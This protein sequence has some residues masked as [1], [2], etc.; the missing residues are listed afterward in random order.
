MGVLVPLQ[1]QLFNIPISGGVDTKTD[2]FQVAA[3][4]ASL[5][6]NARFQK[7]GK[8]SKRF[9]LVSLTTSSND[10]GFAT[11][12]IKSIVSDND[13]LAT[14]TSNGVYAYSEGDNE[15]YKQT[16]FTLSS[17]IKS[18][19]I[20]KNQFN[21]R[22]PDF[23]V[24]SDGTHKLFTC[25]QNSQSSL[26]PIY[27]SSILVVLED[28]STG[29]RKSATIDLNTGSKL[30]GARC[31]VVKDSGSLYCHVYYF[32]GTTVKRNIYDENLSPITSGVI[33]IA[34]SS[35]GAQFDICKDS[36][37]IYLAHLLGTTLDL[38]NYSFIGVQLN[39]RTLTVTNALGTNSSLGRGLSLVKTASNIHI[40]WCGTADVILRGFN[41]NLTNAITEAVLATSE[42]EK[43]AMC[44][45]GNNLVIVNDSEAS[46]SQS[47]FTEYS[48]A[49]FTTTYSFSTVRNL[50]R[51]NLASQPFV[52]ESKNFVI[53]KTNEA[54]NKN[55]YLYNLTDGYIVQRFSPG[56]A[57]SQS[58][59]GIVVD[60]M[61][62]KTTV[63]DN[64]AMTN[65]CRL[66]TISGTDLIDQV[67]S[68]TYNTHDFNQSSSINGKFKVGKSLY[69]ISGN[70]M[71][72][73]KLTAFENGF[74]FTPKITAVTAVAGV[75]NPN[76]SSKNFVYIAV[77]EFYNAQGERIL[78]APSPAFTLATTGA[79]TQRID[80]SVRSLVLSLKSKLAFNNFDTTVGV[81]IYRTTSGGS[82]FYRVGSSLM[83]FNNGNTE[84]ISDTAA[85]TTI[86][87][88]E[89][90]YTTGDVL[91]NDPAPSAEFSVSGGN[92]LFLGGLE[93]RDEVAYSK[94]QLFGEAVAF[95]D[96]FR[97]R[98]STGTNAD[99]TPISAL[100][101]MDAKLIIFRE[102]SIYYIQG[103]GPN[104]LGVGSF[105][106][107]E[108]VQSDVGCVDARSVLSMPNGLMFKSRKGIYLLDRGLSVSYIGAQVE[109][110]NNENIISS[111][112]SDKFNECRFYTD[113]GNCLV[114]NYLFG[115]WSVFL[116]QTSVDADNWKGSPVS[117][118]GDTVF[119][120]SEGTYLDNGATGF[121]PMKY[122]SPWLKLDMIQGYFR[123]YRLHILGT[124]KSNH[125]L[126]C[127]IYTDYDETV[128][129]DYDLI[130]N[131]TDQPQYQFTIHIPKQ[132]CESIKFEIFDDAHESNSNG[133]AYDLSNIQ[134]EIGFKAGGFK[135]AR[136]K[137][138]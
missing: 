112:L 107:P 46:N 25:V 82:T 22:W 102:Q 83:T 75:A 30:R 28:S 51:I 47:C 138:Y 137:S 111:I 64:V 76:I 101:Y 11:A 71:E 61:V 90:L 70:V 118:I 126:K 99:K 5:L 2:P 110:Y 60:A 8:L 48:T 73:D 129:D 117:I 4:N 67:A 55:Y 58:I 40:A 39:D 17:V 9:G 100:G 132:K 92:R 65:I 15:W 133:E 78:S 23:D 31:L 3:P 26:G 119:K 96:F 33:V 91:E 127:K 114:Y 41:T 134:L 34:T 52:V 106:D 16:F 79:S 44:A 108:V 130:L 38:L 128:S 49:T 10:G 84:V 103:D 18:D 105:S 24:T 56:L 121:Y 37:G 50:Q 124:N 14:V 88:N 104:E 87:D 109:D 116:N 7:T 95:S 59:D 98:I 6:E 131:T 123:A 36:S 81:A 115:T 72:F 69:Y 27:D 43:V 94:K 1:K 136:T 93:E 20:A 122:V 53:V 97:I 42:I 85:D 13:Y 113:Q 54:E 135:L 120:E 57:S 86:D 21:Q 74:V 29:L 19:Y 62:S 32:D 45:N 68:M 89:Q 80:I 35:T 125:T 63:L 12:S 77:Y 66:S